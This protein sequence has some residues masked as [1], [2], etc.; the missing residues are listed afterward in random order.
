MVQVKI[1]QKVDRLDKAT[2]QEDAIDRPTCRRNFRSQLFVPM[3][4]SIISTLLEIAISQGKKH[5]MSIGSEKVPNINS[6]CD[7]RAFRDTHAFRKPND[8]F[9]APISS[10][11]VHA[12]TNDRNT[13]QQTVL[14]RSNVKLL[15][16]RPLHQGLSSHP[17]CFLL[18]TLQPMILMKWDR[19]FPAKWHRLC[20]IV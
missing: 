17:F 8:T 19:T 9:S 2:T 13:S 16:K 11:T 4:A 14:T 5:N 3:R 15:E 18:C 10:S 20:Q 1:A 12:T 6:R 7:S